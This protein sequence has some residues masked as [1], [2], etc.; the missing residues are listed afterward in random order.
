MKKAIVLAAGRGTRMNSALPKV[1]HEVAGKPMVLHVLETLKKASMDEVV[2]VIA[3]DMEDVKKTVF[4]YRTVVQEK[5]LG[6][7]HAAL[8]AH[9]IMEP[10]EGC[11]FILFGDAP[12][13]SVKTLNQMEQCFNAGNEIV[14][15]GFEAEDPKHYGRL[16]VGK[17]G[18]ERIVE[19]KDATDEE[20]AITLCNAGNMCVSG[21]KLFSLLTEIS[22]SPVTGEYYLP[23]LVRLGRKKGLSI[24][25]VTADEHEVL[26]INTQEELADA[27]AMLS[28]GDK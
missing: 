18:L 2:V 28:K 3:P 22:P 21:Q 26:G 7:A 17:K 25:V 13:M 8:A 20:R 27:N 23:E 19:Y 9:Q 16:V 14:V 11:A 5:P 10:F 6:T 24:G 1:L 12:L 4:P 15:V